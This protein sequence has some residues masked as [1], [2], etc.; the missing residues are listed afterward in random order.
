[1]FWLEDGCGG[2]DICHSSQKGA[3]MAKAE[4]EAS[5]TL[6]T[7]FWQKNFVKAPPQSCL[8]G[9]SRPEIEP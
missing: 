3:G 4:L 8:D 5:T 7:R 2:Q 6:E 1:M 9:N